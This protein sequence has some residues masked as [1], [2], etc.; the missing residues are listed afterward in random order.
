MVIK[1]N[2]FPSLVEIPATLESNKKKVNNNG[3]NKYGLDASE[4]IFFKH[5]ILAPLNSIH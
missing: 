5:E 1:V 4:R 3:V 2:I